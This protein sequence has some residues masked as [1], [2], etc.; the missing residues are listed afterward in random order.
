M[1]T[2]LKKAIFVI[3]LVLGIVSSTVL[4]ASADA[5]QYP[6]TLTDMAGREVVI[7]AR[8]ERIVSGYFISSSLAIALGLEDRMVGI[9]GK[10][11]SRPIYA[12][13]APQLLELP[14]VGSAKEF[15]LEGCIALEPDLVILPIKLKDAAEALSKLGIPVLLVNPENR[16][17]FNEMV[18]IIAAATDTTERAA[19]FKAYNADKLAELAAFEVSG[20]PVVY[21][22][23]F[24]LLR[25][26]PGEMYQSTMIENA[27]AVNAA[28]DVKDSSWID[29][30]YEQLIA[31]NPDAIVIIAESDVTK[32]TVLN[33]PQLAAVT[34]VKN[35]AVYEIPDRFEAWDA[36]VPSGVLGSMWLMSVLH[37]NVYPFDTFVSDAAE[38]YKTFYDMDIDTRL[39][40]R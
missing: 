33:D 30:S 14:N 24:E 31:Y 3:L 23:G 5:T 10:A 16:E 39:L 34:A 27:H 6:L 7:E 21:L 26:A 9:E 28:A 1:N 29:I 13:A 15:N 40:S 11:N 12:L 4:T 2:V 36:P 22:V 19:A 35:G 17:L 32:D 37:D 25:T 8:P 38:F 18:D 20:T